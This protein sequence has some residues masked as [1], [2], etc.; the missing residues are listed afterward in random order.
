MNRKTRKRR[1]R[2]DSRGFKENQCP[3]NIHGIFIRA[4]SL[5]C[6]LTF[7]CFFSQCNNELASKIANWGIW[8][9]LNSIP[10][11]TVEMLVCIAAIVFGVA[12]IKKL[13][14]AI[15]DPPVMYTW[16][17]SLFSLLAILCNE[18]VTLTPLSKSY[19]TALSWDERN[20][21]CRRLF[22]L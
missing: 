18:F 7:V 22:N 12:F 11:F 2:R 13:N 20:R 15:T 3:M 16:R 10:W 8:F 14:P 9:T 5:L 1:S 17:Q 4:S 21:L 6:F 19:L